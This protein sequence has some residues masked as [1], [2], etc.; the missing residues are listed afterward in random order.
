MSKS[1]YNEVKT[2]VE[3]EHMKTLHT[4]AQTRDKMSS[5]IQ[6]KEQR[7]GFELN[8]QFCSYIHYNS[9]AHMFGPNEEDANSLNKI[10][11]LIR[12]R[13]PESLCEVAVKTNIID[14]KTINQLEN[15]VFSTENMQ[16]LYQLFND[17]ILIDSTYKTNKFNMPL[18]ILTGISE[19]GKTFMIGFAVL[20]SEKEA[21]V[22]WALDKIFKFLSKKSQ[23]ICSDSCSTLK[24]VIPSLLPDT[25]HLLCAWHVEQ[26]IFCK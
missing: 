26:N 7:D 5:Y 21:N 24:T 20:S 14:N 2:F 16:K 15:F 12:E 18:L 11:N 4:P 8:Y 13:F 25:K 9:K 17:V 22:S 3:K 19:E 23:I 10:F 1:T 6:G